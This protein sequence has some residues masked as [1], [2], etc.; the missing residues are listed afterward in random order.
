MTL[1]LY[2]KVFLKDNLRKLW[3]IPQSILLTTSRNYG[4]TQCYGAYDKNLYWENSTCSQHKNQM[5]TDVSAWGKK[6]KQHSA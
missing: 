5:G 2:R 6:K 4:D 1:N 3:D